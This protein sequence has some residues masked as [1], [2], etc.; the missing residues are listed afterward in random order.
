MSEPN[1]GNPSASLAGTSVSLPADLGIDVAASLYRDLL[2]QVDNPGVVTLEAQ[3][4]ARI[5]T[6]ALQLFCMFCQ[7]RRSAGRETH[8][9]QPTEALRSAAA[10]LGVTTL[11][12]LARQEA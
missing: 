2:A 10:L 3:D 8:W 7:D 9:R 1:A 11:L 4:V 12:Q 5:H 6:A